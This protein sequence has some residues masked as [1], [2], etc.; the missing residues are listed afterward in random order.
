M[1]AF[2]LHVAHRKPSL[3]PVS[4]VH[5]AAHG[6]LQMEGNVWYEG[7]LRNLSTSILPAC[8]FFLRWSGVHTLSN[9]LL[10]VTQCYKLILPHLCTVALKIL[11]PIFRTLRHPPPPPD[12][13]LAHLNPPPPPPPPKG[14]S[15]NPRPRMGSGAKKGKHEKEFV[16]R[17]WRHHCYGPT[18]PPFVTTRPTGRGG[19]G[20][21][22]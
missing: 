5:I 9:S 18:W 19:R 14:P 12:P 10:A 20:S 22:E 7:G 6:S 3:Q 15:A 21:M 2:A 1:C 13:Q 8:N 17:C 16:Q 11:T 4:G